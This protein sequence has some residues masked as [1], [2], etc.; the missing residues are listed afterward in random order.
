MPRRALVLLI[1]LLAGCA[2]GAA[3]VAWQSPV[4]REHPLVGRIWDVGAGRFV[5]EPALVARIGRVRYVLLGEKHDNAD[6][7]ALQA[8]LLCTLTSAGRRPAVAFEMLTPSQAGPLARHLAARPRDAAG[9]AEAVGWKESGWPAWSMYEP[10]AQAA[11]D[12]GLPIV[13]AN[14]DAE[15][16]RAVG[17]GG[18]GAID[19]ALVSRYGLAE[20]L[21]PDVR[22]AMTDEIREAHCGHASEGV[23][24]AMIVV[25]RARDAAMAEAMLTA[26]GSDG[27]VLIAG[28]GHARNDRGVPAS[29]RRIAPAAGIASVAFLEVDAGR[30]D[31]ASYA[32]RFGERLPYDYVWFTPAVDDEDPCEKFKKSLERLRK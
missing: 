12:A 30:P 1:T 28:A 10:I 29:L 7:H 19:A 15:R 26:P 24:S 25:Q 5:D 22:A 17:R 3:R 4:G 6:H 23:A 16:G 9:I 13:A 11:L 18:I 31:P 21:P 8:R 27:A 2:A 14:L 20:P 32:G